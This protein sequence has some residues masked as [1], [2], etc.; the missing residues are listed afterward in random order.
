MAL[1][2]QPFYVSDGTNVRRVTS[3]DLTGANSSGQAKL[4]H[5]VYGSDGTDVKKIW[6]RL[7]GQSFT[8]S[9]EAS[10]SIDLLVRQ[11]VQLSEPGTV[12]D[13]FGLTKIQPTT[14]VFTETVETSESIDLI[15]LKGPT[16]LTASA[17]TATPGCNIALAWTDGSTGETNWE[18]HEHEGTTS[19]TDPYALHD[20]ISA[21]STSYTFSTTAGATHTFKVRPITT[22]EDGPFS[23][24]ATAATSTDCGQE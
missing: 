21:D 19:S 22:G 13:S 1:S 8:E 14:Q 3:T 15:K 20:T 11:F 4:I 24:Q 7:Q 10:E 6:E 23:N 9:V 2:T 5:E 18:V 17:A 12:T 16:D